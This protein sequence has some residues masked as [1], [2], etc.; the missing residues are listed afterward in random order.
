MSASW[1]DVV[2][3]GRRLSDL[4]Q[5][6]ALPWVRRHSSSSATIAA[7]DDNFRI[8]FFGASAGADRSVGSPRLTC[9]YDRTSTLPTAPPWCHWKH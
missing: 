8:L 1:G 2:G 5:Y 3:E 4:Q 7:I 9:P 6:L